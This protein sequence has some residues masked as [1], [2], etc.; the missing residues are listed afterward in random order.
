MNGKRR[1]VKQRE[2]ER[3]AQEAVKNV[4]AKCP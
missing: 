4:P 2:V 1:E 3:R